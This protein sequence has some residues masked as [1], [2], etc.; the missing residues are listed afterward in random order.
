MFVVSVCLSV[1]WLK[2]A[3]ACAVSY[4]WGH[5][6][7]PLSNYFDYCFIVFYVHLLFVILILVLSTGVNCLGR[8]LSEVTC[9]VLSETSKFANSN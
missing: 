6:V 9:Y 3:A 1:T 5:S 8:L 2:S 7:Q 4:V